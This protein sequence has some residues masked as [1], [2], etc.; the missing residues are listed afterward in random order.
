[1]GFLPFV[2]VVVGT[3][4][5]TFL[6]GPSKSCAEVGP[7]KAGGPRLSVEHLALRLVGDLA[8]L[9]ARI[10]ERICVH[11]E[12]GEARRFDHYFTVLSLL[13]R[14]AVRPKPRQEL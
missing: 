4:P 2:V 3:L 1:M 13:L 12:V 6:D 5:S 10:C 14:L 7:P 9:R 11:V 8:R